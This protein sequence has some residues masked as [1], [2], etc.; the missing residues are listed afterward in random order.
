MYLF[1]IFYFLTKLFHF[2]L[3]QN[4]TK[5]SSKFMAHKHTFCNIVTYNEVLYYFLSIL[6]HTAHTEKKKKNKKEMR[7]TVATDLFQSICTP[8]TCDQY[9]SEL[10]MREFICVASCHQCGWL[11]TKAISLNPLYKRAAQC[12]G[13]ICA[14]VAMCARASLNLA[15][16]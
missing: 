9:E 4:R 11:R 8:H 14:I 10:W 13:C 6:N 2:R 3:A 16:H 1:A 12:C 5:L 15:T 7:L